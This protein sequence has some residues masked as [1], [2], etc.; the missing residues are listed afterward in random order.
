[1]YRSSSRPK[2]QRINIGC[3][4]GGLGDGIASLPVI[5]KIHDVYG[6]YHSFNFIVKDA[7]KELT[8]FCLPNA[9]IFGLSD[10]PKIDTS[11]PAIHNMHDQPTFL[12]QH[13]TDWAS[14]MLY[15]G[16]LEPEDKNYLKPDLSDIILKK[17]LTIDGKYAIITT[18][19]T[20]PTRVLPASEVNKITDNLVQ[21]DIKPIF[22]GQKATP[23]QVKDGGYI[24][25]NDVEGIDYSVGIDLRNKT[26]LLELLKLME[27]AEM[28]IGVDNGLL[29]LAAMTDVYIIGGF[30]TVDPEH[31]LPYRHNVK[32]WNYATV[33]PDESLN[34]RFC[35]SKWKFDIGQ[36]FTKCFYNDIKCTTQMTAEKFLERM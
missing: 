31:R 26:S 21:R 20:S 36:D 22:V 3:Y 19:F 18:M 2:R 34:C 25:A 29:H 10:H 12:G 30:T 15:D 11:L 27:K 17:D 33:T 6:S 32:G 14:T 7:L 1:M 9:N 24:K 16:I 23:H 8:Q 5:K 28:V 13:L 35:Q 4:N